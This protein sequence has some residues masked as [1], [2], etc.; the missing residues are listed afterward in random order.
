VAEDQEDDVI[1][2]RSAL[3][4]AGIPNPVHIVADGEECIAYLGGEG[5]YANRDEYPLPGLLLLDLKM[6]RMNGFEVLQWI[7]KDPGLK[8]LPVVVMT[9]SDRIFDINRA[10]ELGAN[11][12]VVKTLDIQTFEDLVDQLGRY[13]L[14]LSRAPETE[15][16]AKAP[17]KH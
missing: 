15:R 16:A 3:H 1:L 8:R 4:K 11:S 13:W 14:Q 5:K 7:R 17:R 2:L 9:T 12:F 10:Y 6:P